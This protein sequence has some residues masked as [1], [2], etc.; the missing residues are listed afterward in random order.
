M[1]PCRKSVQYHLFLMYHLLH[2]SHP[3][4]SPRS[5]WYHI[6]TEREGGAEE[7]RRK[8][9]CSVAHCWQVAQLGLE[10]K[11][12][13][14]CCQCRSGDRS[15]VPGVKCWRGKYGKRGSFEPNRDGLKCHD[16]CCPLQWATWNP[17]RCL[18]GKLPLCL[19][20]VFFLF[21]GFFCFVLFWGFLGRGLHLQHMEVPSLGVELELQLPAYATAIATRDLSCIC[22]LYHSSWQHWVLKP[23]S[24]AR[25]RT[26]ILTDTSWVRY[27]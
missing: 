24:K 16:V 19:G 9:A 20:A 4:S 11:L 23:L 25:D 1:N 15:Q 10:A 6:Y 5:H 14:P 12:S 22:Y 17:G 26:L 27:H 13:N 18:E 8:P 3:H 2:L 21:W 7:Q